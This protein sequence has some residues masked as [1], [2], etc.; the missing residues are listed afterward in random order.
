[1]QISGFELI[2]YDRASAIVRF[3]KLACLPRVVLDCLRSD[4]LDTE[5]MFAIFLD[6]D[7]EP[8]S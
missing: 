2:Q 6:E 3:Q 1:M 8:T 7:I 5:Q 4:S